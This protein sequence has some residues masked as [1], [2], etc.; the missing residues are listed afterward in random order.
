M[1]VKSSAT[2]GISC[3]QLEALFASRALAQ[4]YFAALAAAFGLSV[5]RLFA[6]FGGP[7][8][9]NTRPDAGR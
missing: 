1:P 8:V 4:Q 9:G 3:A 6:L 2:F 7:R 5:R